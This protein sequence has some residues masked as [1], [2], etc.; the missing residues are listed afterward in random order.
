MILRVFEADLNQVQTQSWGKLYSLLSLGRI[1][2]PKSTANRKG[3]LVSAQVPVT[4]TWGKYFKEVYD[5]AYGCFISV[6]VP[7]VGVVLFDVVTTKKGGDFRCCFQW[8]FS[9]PEE[10]G[11]ETQMLGMIST[12]L[13]IM[14]AGF[15]LYRQTWQCHLTG[16]PPFQVYSVG[17]FTIKH[18]TSLQPETTLEE[19]LPRYTPNFWHRLDIENEC[20]SCS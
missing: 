11:N 5:P 3:Q 12:W 2:S 14:S 6:K 7:L 10:L 17:C 8:C 4:E 16:F 19:V 15:C 9:Y 1:S 18:L 20:D 13:W